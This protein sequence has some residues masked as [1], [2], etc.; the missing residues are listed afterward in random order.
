MSPSWGGGGA[1]A[2]GVATDTFVVVESGFL[3]DENR[4][5]NSRIVS[6]LRMVSFTV[7]SHLDAVV[8]PMSIKGSPSAAT[9]TG[10]NPPWWGTNPL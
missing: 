2:G 7:N 3:P 6:I 1:G 8:I 10:I 4:S 9:A 5:F